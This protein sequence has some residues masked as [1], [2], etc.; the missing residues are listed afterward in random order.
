MNKISRSFS[1]FCR[2]FSRR[3]LLPT[4]THFCLYG[5]LNSWS[6]FL[7][8]SHLFQPSSLVVCT[9]ISQHA[10]HLFSESSAVIWLWISVFIDFFLRIS[11]PCRT[12]IMELFTL[13]ISLFFEVNSFLLLLLLLY[14]IKFFSDKRDFQ[15][16]KLNI[17]SVF[18]VLDWSFKIAEEVIS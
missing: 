13:S 18:S 5:E 7:K 17:F 4:S 15:F 3:N 9:L 2:F 6:Q 11:W 12:E 14:V 10:Q 16:F 8:L 1:A